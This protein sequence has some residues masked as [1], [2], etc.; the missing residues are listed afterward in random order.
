[1]SKPIEIP[2][3]ISSAENQFYEALGK[4]DLEELGT[5]HPMLQAQISILQVLKLL[6]KN[7]TALE[8]IEEMRAFREGEE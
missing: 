6:P 5:N 2:P 3:F 1:M 4:I 8:L 7:F